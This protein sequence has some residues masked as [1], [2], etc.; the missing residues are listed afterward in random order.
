MIDP[1][2]SRAPQA[3]Q[4][5]LPAGFMAFY[6]P[7]HRTFTPRQQALLAKRREALSASL[8][9]R[10]P[11]YLPASDATD[12]DWRIQVPSWAEDQRN[13]MTGPADEAELVVKMLNSGA[14][15]VMLDLEDSMV[16]A[17]GHLTLGVKNILS[18]LYGE[19]TYFDKK[20]NQT[21][22]IKP[23]KTV[24][25]NRVRGLH[26]SQAGLFEG[27]ELT[28]GSLLDLCLIAFQVDASKVKH[29]L[30]FYIPKSE[31]AEEAHW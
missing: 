27:D 9:G 25:W 21:V 19:L 2:I 7:L 20:R 3:A 6:A 30:S 26:L 13:Q 4:Q 8:D 12:G 14:P 18:A 15:G 5:D 31:S 11:G 23:S 1:R 28:S 17:W 10:K 24:I 16:N 22:G 29:P